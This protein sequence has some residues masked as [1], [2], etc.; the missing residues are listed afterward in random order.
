MYL[1]AVVVSTPEWT[2][3]LCKVGTVSGTHDTS[4][5]HGN[6]P[7]TSFTVRIKEMSLNVESFYLFNK[8]VVKYNFNIFFV[9]GVAHK[10]SSDEGPWKS[11][12]GPTQHSAGRGHTLTSKGVSLQLWFSMEEEGALYFEPLPIPECFLHAH[13]TEK[14][15]QKIPYCSVPRVLCFLS[16]II[17]LSMCLV[18]LLDLKLLLRLCF[19]VFVPKRLTLNIYRLNK[20][21]QVNKW[22]TLLPTLAIYGYKY[23]CHL[24]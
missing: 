17:Y 9:E 11:F 23:L 5:A 4:K 7:L 20:C 10:G 21:W 16:I 24:G 18:L 13:S 19:L 1:A 6:G 8:T 2:Y 14:S 15:R 3:P 22:Y 12:H